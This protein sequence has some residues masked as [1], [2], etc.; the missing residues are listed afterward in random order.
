MT[1][2]GWSL[3]HGGGGSC[4]SATRTSL[5]NASEGSDMGTPWRGITVDQGL[6]AATDG[7][8]GLERAGTDIAMVLFPTSPSACAGR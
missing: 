4:P 8:L 7:V 1:W 2:A 3:M 5:G 6:E